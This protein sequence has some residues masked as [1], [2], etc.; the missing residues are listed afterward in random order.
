MRRAA[1]AAAPASARADTITVR[2]L[3]NRADLMAP[4]P[5]SEPLR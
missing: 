1:A 2:T 4:A 5:R 3:S